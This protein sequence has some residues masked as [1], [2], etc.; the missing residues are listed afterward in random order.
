[1]KDEFSNDLTAKG[2]SPRRVRRKVGVRVGVLAF[3]IALQGGSVLFFLGDV[4]ADY[5][6]I[7]FDPHTTSEAIATLALMLGVCFGGLEM[8]RTIRFGRRAEVALKMSGGAFS[9]QLNEKFEVWKL[10]PSESDVALLT[11]KG[12]D[13]PQIAQLRGTAPGTVRA[14]LTSIYG[15][16]NCSGR[17]QFVSLFIDALLDVPGETA[18]GQG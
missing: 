5:W 17:G 7:G 9:E 10:T 1:M 6:A 4:T 18:P 14:Q 16:S 8:L 11:L 2:A 12:F 13:S 3:L 15:K